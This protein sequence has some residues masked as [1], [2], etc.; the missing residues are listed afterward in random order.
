MH[1][2]NTFLWLVNQDCGS[3]FTYSSQQK[4]AKK[5]AFYRFASSL[6][7]NTRRF[8]NYS[9]R[10]DKAVI[11]LIPCF[12]LTYKNNI[13]NRQHMHRFNT[14]RADFSQRRNLYPRTNRNQPHHHCCCR[15]PTD[16]QTKKYEHLISWSWSW[17]NWTPRHSRFQAT[18]ETV[19]R[20]APHNSGRT[21]APP[22][23]REYKL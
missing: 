3:L 1:H 15:R 20:M 8:A 22:T 14:N 23:A 17:R 16:Q 9:A 10:Q 13:I 19:T 18:T 2:I 12:K 7:T 4:F 21:P 5:F 6:I 11:V